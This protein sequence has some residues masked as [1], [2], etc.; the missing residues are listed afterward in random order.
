MSVT[1][2]A[3]KACRLPY[4]WGLSREVTVR[5]GVAT[6]EGSGGGGGG[7]GLP[8]VFIGGSFLQTLTLFQTS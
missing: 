4:N 6:C 2:G 8:L 5:A 3:I 7:R 1:F